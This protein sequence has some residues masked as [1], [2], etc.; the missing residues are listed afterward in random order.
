M[1][2]MIIFLLVL[3]FAGVLVAQGTVD[4]EKEKAAIKEVLE[5]SRNA[6]W[7]KK[8]D[9]YINCWKHESYSILTTVTKNSFWELEGWDS[10]SVNLKEH[11]ENNPDPQK[12]VAFRKNYVIKIWKNTAW[13]YF[14]DFV[15]KAA[16]KDS[17]YVP[18]RTYTVFE[19]T[20]EGWKIVSWITMDRYTWRKA[21]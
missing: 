13:A 1:R 12:P 9:E 5:K 20:I 4:V 7:G 15:M 11:M 14:E 2:K 17:S 6:L 21:E 8:Y 16:E 3:M 10:I 19:K 18:W